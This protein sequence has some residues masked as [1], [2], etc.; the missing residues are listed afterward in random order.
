MQSCYH[1]RN[2][3]I[4]SGSWQLSTAF[5]RH[6]HGAFPWARRHDFLQL[7][8]PL[9]VLPKMHVSFRTCAMTCNPQDFWPDIQ[10]LC[11]T[12]FRCAFERRLIML[13]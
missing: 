11:T 2:P 13:L 12:R 5:G 9:V 4:P 1:C 7:E 10:I 8:S 3:I 6:L